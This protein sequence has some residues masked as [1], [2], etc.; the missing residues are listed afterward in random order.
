MERLAGIDASFLYM[1]TPQ[2]HMQV[3]FACVF[4]P[5]DSPNGY[6]PAAVMKHVEERTSC[7]RV[8]RRRLA[9]VP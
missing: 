8:F 4:D 3:S 9:R 2:V 5:S 7:H 1:E 6:D